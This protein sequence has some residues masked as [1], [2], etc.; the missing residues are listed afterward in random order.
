MPRP[1]SQKE[2]IGGVW[3]MTFG[4]EGHLTALLPSL[5]QPNPETLWPRLQG[6]HL[7]SL[8]PRNTW[9]LRASFTTTPHATQPCTTGPCPDF[10]LHPYSAPTFSN[11]TFTYS[12]PLGWGGREGHT[13]TH[14]LFTSQ[15]S[16]PNVIELSG[17]E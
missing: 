6:P 16:R 12:H 17:K 13:H 5:A 11:F 8:S 1:L 3:H 9:P 2:R 14:S 7:R 10:G 4:S 15:A